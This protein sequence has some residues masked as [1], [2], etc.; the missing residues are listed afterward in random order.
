MRTSIPSVPFLKLEFVLPECI[1]Q[2]HR[3][4]PFGAVVDTYIARVRGWE[5]LCIDVW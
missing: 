1:L 4:G 5:S 3:A 2:S